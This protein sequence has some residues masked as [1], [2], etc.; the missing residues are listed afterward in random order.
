MLKIKMQF[1]HHNDP[2]G[3]IVELVLIL[4]LN[5]KNGHQAEAENI[6]PLKQIYH[7]CSKYAFNDAPL[8]HLRFNCEFSRVSHSV[9]SLQF[10][11]DSYMHAFMIQGVK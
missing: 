2:L 8:P 4:G 10:H 1:G 11:T 6:S 9:N 3:I 7:F 5:D